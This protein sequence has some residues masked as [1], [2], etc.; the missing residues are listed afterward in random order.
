MKKI[1]L[2]GAA[3]FLGQRLYKAFENDYSIKLMDV[4]DFT[5]D[6]E[7]IVG[8]VSQ[9]ETCKA[10]IEGVDILVIAHMFPR[11]YTTPDGPY[12][13]NVKGT[14]NL[15]HAAH[16]AG[17]KRV[18]LVSSVD[19][20]RGWDKSIKREPCLRPQGNDLYTTTK[21]CQEIVAE[22]FHNETGIEIGVLRVGY[23]V[24]L[25]DMVDKYGTK[26][27][28]AAAGMVDRTDIGVIARKVIE[29][30]E[31]NYEVHYVYSIVNQECE[32]SMTSTIEQLNWKP[33]QEQEK[34]QLLNV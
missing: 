1:L 16:E 5:S 29:K 6:H 24:D 25:D 34:E 18:V 3:G 9:P 26:L 20:C 21:A 14:A 4:V 33:I 13:A 11:P 28:R 30:T 19:A 32:E 22:S 12:D 2:T 7:I 27:P 31:L 17:I 10:A 8:D 15:L 23:I